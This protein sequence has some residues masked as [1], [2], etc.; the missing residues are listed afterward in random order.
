MERKV[1]IATEE[2]ESSK[3]K[4]CGEISGRNTPN[5]EAV[6]DALKEIRI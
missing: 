3:L 5:D 4:D 2:I 6:E 1:V